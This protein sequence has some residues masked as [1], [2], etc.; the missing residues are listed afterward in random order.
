MEQKGVPMRRMCGASE[1]HARLCEEY[2][3]FRIARGKIHAET[4]AMIRSG[5]AFRRAKSGPIK[6]TVVVHVVCGTA[7][8]N[9]SDAQVHSQI[10]ALNRDYSA[11]N[12]DKA[13]TPAEARALRLLRTF[14][15]PVR[16]RIV[17]LAPGA[18][19][20]PPS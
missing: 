4:E 10:D 7:A 11:T 6:I 20:A 1:A 17:E 5:A 3:E 16:R 19:I 9:I 12:A 8:D 13:Q 15:S 18:R 14:G 2:P